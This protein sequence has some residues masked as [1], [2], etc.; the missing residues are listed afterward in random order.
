MYR[1]GQKYRTVFSEVCDCR[2]M[3]RIT[4]EW[5]NVIYTKLFSILSGVRLVYC[6]TLFEYSLRNFSVT[7][8][9]SK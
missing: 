8:L 2:I 6:F 3:H 7:T 5:N 4:R 1:V 9:R